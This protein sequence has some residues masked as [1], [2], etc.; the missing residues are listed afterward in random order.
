MP[1]QTISLED[2]LLQWRYSMY[3]PTSSGCLETWIYDTSPCNWTGI[4]CSAMVPYGHGH[5]RSDVVQVVNNISLAECFLQGTFDILEFPYLPELSFLDLSS[6]YLSGSLPASIG[7]LSKLNYLNL[8]HS[9]GVG[10]L[11]GHIPETLG[12]LVYLQKLDLRGNKFSDLI[13][14]SLGNLTGLDYMDLSSNS[15]SGHIPHEIGMIQGLTLFDLS[16]NSIDGSIPGIIWNLTR[17][18]LLDLSSNRIV[19]SIPLRISLTM[20]KSSD[21]SFNH[22]VGPIPPS[23]G[24]LRRLVSF[25]FA[26]NEITGSIPVSKVRIV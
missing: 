10:S 19:D 26:N 11:S 6:N 12:M 20:L 8:S 16:S 5:G 4:T 7:N 21:L 17:L 3:D 13:P 18:V 23:I 25:G 14:S 24:N 1:Y 15:S 2:M 22:I 9:S